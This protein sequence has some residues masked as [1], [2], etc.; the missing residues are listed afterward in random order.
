MATLPE[1]AFGLQGVLLVANGI[2]TLLYP[3]KAADPS[4]PLSG[5]PVQVVHAIR[6]VYD[7]RIVLYSD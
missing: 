2:Y 4:S 3:K 7:M 1:Y 5:T 6:F